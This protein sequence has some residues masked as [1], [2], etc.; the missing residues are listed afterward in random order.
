MSFFDLTRRL[1]WGGAFRHRAVK[2]ARRAGRTAAMPLSSPRLAHPVWCR[3]TT[4]DFQVFDQVFLEQEFAAL[5]DLR[6]VRTIV[7]G[8]ANV[9][10]A[11]AWLLSAFPEA[12]LVAVE[13]DPENAAMC[14]RNLAPYGA[15]AI[16]VEGGIWPTRARLTLEEAPFRD[17]G[18]WSRQVRELRGDE[19]GGLDAYAIPDLL[20]MLG[21][22]ELSLLK[23]DIEGAEVPLFRGDVSAWLP[24]TR[25]IATEL[26]ADTHFGD[27]PAAFSAAIAGEGFVVSRSS[28]LTIAR[29]A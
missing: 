14:R 21:A 8:G 6:D 25:V 13:P 20:Q 28:E 7:D 15:R 24:R 18:A 22:S 17:G 5:D 10:Y 11:S 4:S 19:L 1:G 26:H 23:L 29:R 2:Q 27:G 9:G 12:R 3:P 16:V